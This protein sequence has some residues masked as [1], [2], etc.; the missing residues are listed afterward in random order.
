MILLYEALGTKERFC[1]KWLE[2]YFF[3]F[4]CNNQ[5]VCYPSQEPIPH[6]HLLG[7]STG[8]A[9]TLPFIH[10]IFSAQFLYSQSASSQ[11]WRQE[12]GAVG[13]W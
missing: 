5:L 4:L 8:P 13:D 10:H 11:A 9:E 7:K 1:T 6:L 12:E 3:Y 2:N